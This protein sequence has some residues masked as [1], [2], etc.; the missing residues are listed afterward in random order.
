MWVGRRCSKKSRVLNS[1]I[2]FESSQTK[3]SAVKR[4]FQ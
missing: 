4:K 2:S 1:K 3:T